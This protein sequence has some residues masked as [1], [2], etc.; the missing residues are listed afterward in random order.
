MDTNFL[1]KCGTN[2]SSGLKSS[3]AFFYLL[4]VPLVGDGSFFLV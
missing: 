2:I 3:Q 4:V 1:H